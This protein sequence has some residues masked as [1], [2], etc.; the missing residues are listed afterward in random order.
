MRDDHPREAPD[1]TTACVVMFG[2]NVSL[3]LVAIWAIWGLIA[4]ML[5]GYGL[6]KLLT[7]LGHWRAARRLAAIRRGKDLSFG[8]DGRGSL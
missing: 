1:F 5:L 7:R 3:V 6:D 8:D 4:A 2:V